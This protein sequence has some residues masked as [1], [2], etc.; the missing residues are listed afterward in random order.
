M[1]NNTPQPTLVPAADLLRQLR[2]Q[3]DAIQRTLG[4]QPTFTS[5]MNTALSQHLSV[6]VP[7]H[8]LDPDAVFLNEYSRKDERVIT[9]RTLNEVLHAAIT[10]GQLPHTLTESGQGAGFYRS[11]EG[12][13]PIAE[14]TELTLEAFNSLIADLSRDCQATYEDALEAFWSAPHTTT[15][16]L[17]VHEA[18]SQQQRE[19]LRLEADLMRADTEQALNGNGEQLAVQRE[20]RQLI[21]NLLN[22]EPGGNHVTSTPV[23]SLVLIAPDPV[24]VAGA[25]VLAERLHSTRP[26]V[27]YTPQYG[28]EVF[29][30]FSSMENTLRR[31]LV[32]GVERARLLANVPFSQ[33]ARLSEV[34]REGQ[35]LSYTEITEPV[36]SERLRSQRDQQVADIA[37][38]ARRT[39]ER[40]PLGCSEK[41]LARL[42]TVAVPHLAVSSPN[43]L[44]DRAQQVHLI[45]LLG[46]LNDQIAQVL[47][48][49][50][51]AQPSQ[52][53]EQVTAFWST[54]APQRLVDLY[55]Q[56]LAV[57]ARLRWA[58]KTLTPRAKWLIDCAVHYPTQAQRDAVFREGECPGVYQLT[59][60]NG[61]PEGARLAASFILA[62]SDGHASIRVG[63]THGPLVLYTP[64]Q[65]FEEFADAEQ[66]HQ[67]LAARI[68]AGEAAGELLAA[69]LPLA[70]AQAK[71]G[72]WGDSLHTR[73]KPIEGDFVASSLQSLFDK[74]SDDIDA[75]PDE[76]QG[77]AELAEQLDGASA[78][79]ARTQLLLDNAR[80]DWE[81]QLSEADQ[82]LLQTQ[83]RAVEEK[84]LALANLWP[85]VPSLQAY[86]K[87]RVLD[88][89]R[90]FLAHKGAQ[91][92][93]Q[94]IDPDQCVVTHVKRVRLNRSGFG[95]LHE[96]TEIK[97]QSLTDLVLGNT[98]P[99]EKSFAWQSWDSTSARLVTAAGQ[100]VDV[101]QDVLEQWLNALNVGPNYIENV[102]KKKLDP[103]AVTG[104]AYDLKHAWMAAQSAVLHYEVLYARLS[105][106]AYC[107]PLADE[108]SHK[109]GAQWMAA[110]LASPNP[111]TRR[112]VDGQAVI[113]NALLF[114][115][116]NSARGGQRVNGVLV[117]ST[118]IDESIVL[119]TPDAPD[120]L[121][122]REV[123]TEGDFARMV[124]SSSA[125][126]AY[127]QARLP[128]NTR[129]IN[130]RL[131]PHTENFLE[132]LYRQNVL[133]L[134]QQVD[135]QTI[136]NEERDS[137]STFNKVLFGVEVVTTLLGMFPWA[138][139]RAFS[140]LGWLGTM[141]RTGLHTWRRS[142]QTIP[143]LIVR[144]GLAGR[145]IAELASETAGHAAGIGVTPLRAAAGAARVPAGTPIGSTALPALHG[146]FRQQRSNLAFPGGVPAG[147]SL[148]TGTGIY[149]APGGE[150]LV[151]TVED[152]VCRV[153][154]A[155]TLYGRTGRVVHV[156]TP[157]GASTSFR[158]RQAAHQRWSLDTLERA[159]GGAPERVTA[160]MLQDWQA[161]L[162]NTP[163]LK[164]H[165]F[166]ASHNVPYFTWTNLVSAKTGVLTALGRERL[167][168]GGY[169][170]LTDAL[171][172]EWVG[173][174]DL[175]ELSANGF[176]DLHRIKP[177]VW[178]A[179]FKANGEATTLGLER[180]SKIRQKPMKITDEILLEWKQLSSQPA[181]QNKAAVEAFARRHNLHPPSWRAMVNTQG[182]F[183]VNRNTIHRVTRLGLA[184]PGPTP[185]S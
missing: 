124:N 118:D 54:C 33:R 75:Q 185:V 40:L 135:A 62:V 177:A 147:S 181:Y 4:C 14:I 182:A 79:L 116:A 42:E 91:Y 96:S 173:R 36:F 156:L 136:S 107:T 145:V 31:R 93:A 176:R 83:A 148:S 151:R 68:N 127:L 105:P 130:P 115:P 141:A 132:A 112:P 80:P 174:N 56:V 183:R 7:Q 88:K 90:E 164:P 126:Q 143:G 15:C 128:A 47:N 77:F 73:F 169:M 2:L 184:P 171:F 76:G 133:H 155:F 13:G 163:G 170:R 119:Y 58:D 11:T 104:D 20:G 27:L 55:R 12:A 17:G 97:R 166:F 154:D 146:A 52:S 1:D 180:L 21:E 72:L 101:P 53:L 137:Q 125:W 86:A 38:R 94:G 59:V 24:P 122:L 57:Q 131:A 161:L 34:L 48:P 10:T 110:V 22:G 103:D 32:D 168:P 64:G 106:D 175:T 46:D 99:W 37:L 61:T 114:N 44:A 26:V 70:V 165:D 30:T 18:L 85:R 87:A 43:G 66:L 178:A 113:V 109:R 150:M 9:S 117:V 129:L 134:I 142:G 45:R 89:I 92:S 139:Q 120:G 63:E 144:Q 3:T 28:I 123:K 100:H 160:Q 82:S 167:N 8:V 157:S 16:G 172:L 95:E 121:L 35:S 74:Q 50:L 162:A 102:L 71:T 108:N 69:S 41:L 39:V 149:R 78:F 67:V 19:V 111:Q 81:K 159:V 6:L 153:Q 138:T 98:H 23:F 51:E 152:V 65:G 29:A 140:A 25:F 158:L 84:Q 60:D 49:A 5:V 179:N